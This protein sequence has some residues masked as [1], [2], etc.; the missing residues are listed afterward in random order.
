MNL[1]QPTTCSCLPITLLAKCSSI[2]MDFRIGNDGSK[3]YFMTNKDAPMF[4]IISIDISDPN[5]T[6]TEIVPEDKEAK[7]ESADLVNEDTLALVYKR[8]VSTGCLW[9]LPRTRLLILF[10]MVYT[11][12]CR[13]AVPLRLVREAPEETGV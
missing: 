12:G 8:N 4:K 11:L 10:G 7:L 6:R 1:M 13:R 5:F 2:R 3:F 9:L